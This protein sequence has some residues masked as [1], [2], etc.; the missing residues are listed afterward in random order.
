MRIMLE[1]G[2]R[3]K[4]RNAMLL[5][6]F[7]GGVPLNNEKAGGSTPGE[8]L[9]ATSIPRCQGLFPI[10]KYR[11]YS[12]FRFPVHYHHDFPMGDQ[13]SWDEDFYTSV[14]IW[15]FNFPQLITK[16]RKAFSLEHGQRCTLRY[17]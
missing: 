9:A 14:P 3:P 4:N 10:W 6:L 16:K 5:S 13:E 11:S 12:K 8:C 15:I 1:G 2:D 7:N 17:L